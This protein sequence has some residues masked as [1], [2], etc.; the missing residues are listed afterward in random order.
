MRSAHNFWLGRPIDKRS[1]QL[2]CILQDLF[3]DTPL[4]CIKRIWISGNFFAFF[5]SASWVH[6]LGHWLIWGPLEGSI[7]KLRADYDLSWPHPANS[8]KF[9]W[10]QMACTDVSHIILHILCWTRTYWGH[11]RPCKN[12]FSALAERSSLLLRQCEFW[13]YCF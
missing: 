12:S 4:D 9:L 10:S 11:F 6:I 13:K 8:V 3:R 1:M 5:D 2:K 7:A